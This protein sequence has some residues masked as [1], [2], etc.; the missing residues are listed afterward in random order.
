GAGNTRSTFWRDR[1]WMSADNTLD[2]SDRLLTTTNH[3][4]ALEPGQS[5]AASANVTLPIGVSGNFF[6]IV[7]TDVFNEVFE[8]VFDSNNVGFV[9]PATTVNLTP[10]PD[11]EIDFVDAPASGLAG[12]PITIN[13]GV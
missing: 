10:P 7:Q 2:G 12:Q 4:G 13:F 9:D 1:I 5:Y 8:H 6:F 3:S 11:L